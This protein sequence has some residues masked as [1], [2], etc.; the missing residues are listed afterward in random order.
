MTENSSGGLDRSYFVETGIS[1]RMDAARRRAAD[2]LDAALEHLG[3]SYLDGV[4]FRLNPDLA[5]VL[6][7]LETS[8]RSSDALLA[9]VETRSRPLA[10]VR[11]PEVDLLGLERR[12]LEQLDR[13]QRDAEARKLRVEDW[14]RR[15]SEAAA[16][17]AAA[18][19]ADEQ[20]K[21]AERANLAEE[22]QGQVA[23]ADDAPS[24]ASG[25]LE[26]RGATKSG[27][28]EQEEQHLSGVVGSKAAR[29]M[30]SSYSLQLQPVL[31][32]STPAAAPVPAA[33]TSDSVAGGSATRKLTNF[34][35][36]EAE[37]D[38][39][40]RAE[41][42]TL[43]EMKVL[44]EV[45]GQ[46]VQAGVADQPQVRAPEVDH[47]APPGQAGYHPYQGLAF[48]GANHH[49]HHHLH[50]HHHHPTMFRAGQRFYHQNE[51]GVTNSPSYLGSPFGRAAAPGH[52]Q[53]GAGL[54]PILAHGGFSSAFHSD[55]AST[56][57]GDL[58]AAPDGGVSSLL[59]SMKG[60][61]SVGD[62]VK[63]IKDEDEDQG[64]Q[65][66]PA[67]DN[68]R[69]H[70][71]AHPTTTFQPLNDWKPALAS[72]AGVQFGG[73]HR[74]PSGLHQDL[75]KTTV[76]T[77]ASSKTPPPVPVSRSSYTTRQVKA[78]I[79][80]WIP[81]PDLDGGQQAQGDE[82][83]ALLE[84]LPEESRKVCLQ[85]QDMGFPLAR[86]V[87]GCRP[88]A[89]GSDSQ[90]LINFCLL[91]D[92]LAEDLSLK[93]G[94]ETEEVE[95]ALL[96]H[97]LKTEE[98]FRHIQAFRKLRDLGFDSRAIHEALMDTPDLD[99]TKALEKLLGS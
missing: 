3:F 23:V 53:V 19:S 36:F 26:I 70:R 32:A 55:A 33:E 93:S 82:E 41:L 52:Y 38:P 67:A 7:K 11:G 97:D 73:A 6:S 8:V 96:M 30:P 99:H 54:P 16:A 35:E 39:F 40:E 51:V 9:S 61:K 42:Q 79:A 1:G 28:Q 92:K 76:G 34:A 87:R 22:E 21:S 66:L 43:N 50:H 60:S 5:Q 63:G 91:V 12:A 57:A 2:E 84:G 65:Y 78:S 15:R 46:T 90:Q 48:H 62:L 27:R 45:L 10:Q 89:L 29:S 94:K 59:G 74:P 14:A 17:A 98:A 37:S 88:Q 86:V 13:L 83:K 68:P 64:P 75:F 95:E 80:D 4:P 69:P 44:A 72:S 77:R 20:A 49:H 25:T 81:W 56:L 85:L 58:A 47:A 24:E 31:A 71:S 18:K